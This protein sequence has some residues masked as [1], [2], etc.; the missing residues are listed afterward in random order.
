MICS[1]PRSA[2]AITLEDETTIETIQP[3]DLYDLFEQNPP[4]VRM[5]LSHLSS[6]LRRLT[7]DYLNACRLVYQVTK[8]EENNEM[9]SAEIQ[10]ET[11]E[12]RAK[13]VE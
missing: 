6:R 11:E 2:T 10:K 8:A 1:D 3:E 4:K 5:I 7:K 12:Y 9:P 13:T